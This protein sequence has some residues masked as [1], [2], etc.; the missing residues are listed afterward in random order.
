MGVVHP[1]HEP[2]DLRDVVSVL[3][4]LVAQLVNPLVLAVEIGR[5]RLLQFGHRQLLRVVDQVLHRQEPVGCVDAAHDD[6]RDRVVVGPAVPDLGSAFNAPL[7][8][9]GAPCD[10]QVLGA[11]DARD[12]CL[13]AEGVLTELELLLEGRVQLLEVLERLGISGLGSELL[14][15]AGIETVVQRQL[16]DLPEVGL[17]LDGVACLVGD[18]AAHAGPDA[19]SPR[20]SLG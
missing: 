13:L 7:G 1:A 12:P 15:G 2:V 3:G 10:G 17:T 20:F 8:Q 4:S 14:L 19:G 9:D 6:L 11:Q 18:V 5:Q 16:K